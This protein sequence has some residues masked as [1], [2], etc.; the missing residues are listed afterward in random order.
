MRLQ[1]AR[2]ANSEKDAKPC[3][4]SSERLFLPEQHDAVCVCA[5]GIVVNSPAVGGLGKFLVVDE[6]EERTKAGGDAAGENGLFQFNGA[7][8]EF[9]DFEGDMPAWFEDAMELAEN[10]GDDLLPGGNFPRN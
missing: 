9:A 7:G 1:T 2:T 10:S 5:F 6:D 4:R 3:R 8:A